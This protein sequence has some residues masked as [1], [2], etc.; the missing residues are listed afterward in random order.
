M[1]PIY[2]GWTST[3]NGLAREM[4]SNSECPRHEEGTFSVRGRVPGRAGGER[5]NNNLY[6]RL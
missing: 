1:K 6:E 5:K 3:Q 2:V 4:A